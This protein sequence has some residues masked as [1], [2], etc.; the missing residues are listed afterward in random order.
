LDPTTEDY[1]N[2]MDKLL[3]LHTFIRKEG[4]SRHK[5]PIESTFYTTVLAEMQEWE[6]LFNQAMVNLE[7]QGFLYNR[8]SQVLLRSGKSYQ[9]L[10]TLEM[11]ALKQQYSP[12]PDPL[13]EISDFL[14]SAE[15]NSSPL[16]ESADINEES[17]VGAPLGLPHRETVQNLSLAPSSIVFPKEQTASNLLKVNLFN[18]DIF[19]SGLSKAA[20]RKRSASQMMLGS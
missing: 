18:N 11:K 6:P 12:P 10:L 4:A 14:F 1:I 15:K 19:K 17:K 2:E 7:S 8:H 13:K 3:K 5:L 9:Q 16:T 20:S